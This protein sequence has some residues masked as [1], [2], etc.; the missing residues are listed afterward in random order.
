MVKKRRAL[1]SSEINRTISSRPTIPVAFG[2]SPT[3]EYAG[4]L[5]KSAGGIAAREIGAAKQ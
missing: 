1:S 3:G 2:G 5:L 4:E